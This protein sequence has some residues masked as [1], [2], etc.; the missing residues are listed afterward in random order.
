MVYICSFHILFYIYIGL[1]CL[2]PMKIKNFASS[3]VM[4]ADQIRRFV[5]LRQVS[6]VNLGL[7]F[8]TAVS[9]A[10]VAG[11]DA[12]RAYN[13]FPR[14]LEA[15]PRPDG[16]DPSIPHDSGPWFPSKDVLLEMNPLYRNFFE[17]TATVQLNHRT[18]ATVTLTSIWASYVPLRFGGKGAVIPAPAS[19]VLNAGQFNYKTLPRL[20][21]VGLTAMTHMSAV[22]VGLGISAL[23]MY[24]PTSLG[25]LHQVRETNSAVHCVLFTS[26]IYFV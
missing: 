14:M 26:L 1:E 19:D 18:L 2:N 17:N 23:L 5:R 20:T 3:V 25:V 12:G 8:I 9:G 6:L 16:L 11:N 13:T 22:Q 21:Q 4:S 24:V 15:I 7:V 10:F